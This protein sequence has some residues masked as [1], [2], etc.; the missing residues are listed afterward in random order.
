MNILQSISQ[1][2]IP[3]DVDRGQELV[4]VW[5]ATGRLADLLRGVGGCSPF[6]LSVLTKEKEWISE[7]LQNETLVSTLIE[8]DLCVDDLRSAKRR[9]AGYLALAELSGAL[10]LNRCTEILSDFADRSIQVSLDDALAPFIKAGKIP[11]NPGLF[12]LAMG[13]LG[14]QELN[15]SSDIDLIV[16]FEDAHLDPEGI[17]NRRQILSK[18]VRKAMKTLSDMT[19]DGYVFRT[20]L[21][22]RPDPSVTPVCVGT[23]AAMNYYESLGRTW[24][25]AAFI[26]ARVCAGDIDAGNTFLTAL[27]PFVWRRHLDFAAIE[28]AHDLRLKIRTKKGLPAQITLPGHDMKLGRGGIRE[29]EFFTQTRQLISGGR[30]PSLR[31]AKTLEGLDQLAAAGWVEDETAQRLKRHYI[32]HRHTEH[33]LQMVRDAQTQSLPHS[34]EGL[35]RIAAMQGM[36]VETF[37]EKTLSA[38]E[39]VHEETERFFTSP[40]QVSQDEGEAP[41][42]WGAGADELIA[43]WPHYPALR[44][45]RATGL[46]EKLRPRILNGLSLSADPDAALKDFDAF[47]RGLPSGVQLFSLFAANEKLVDLITSVSARSPALARYLGRNS[48]I[49]DAVLS[50]DF[51][52]SGIL[53]QNL[54]TD[55]SEQL[56]DAA[57]FETGLDRAR[58][59]QKEK[60]FQIGVLLLEGAI[61]PQEART[62]YS[63]LAKSSVAGLTPFALRFFE[64]KHGRIPD[65]DFTVVAMGSLGA[66]RLTSNSDLDLMVI[67]SADPSEQSDG[68]RSLFARQYFARLTQ[69]I[70]TSLSAPTAKGTMY[71]VDMRL[72]PSG[73]SGPVATRLAAFEDYQ[74]NEAW[75]WEHLALTQANPVFSTSIFDQQFNAIRDGILTSKM[76]WSA[77][78]QGLVEMR[79]RLFE[80]KT[81]AGIWDLKNGPGGLQDIELFAQACNLNIGRHLGDM[82]VAF[83]GTRLGET[84]SRDLSD[85]HKTL[86]DIKTCHVLLCTDGGQ[87]WPVGKGGWQVVEKHCNLSNEVQ[88]EDETSNLRNR[89]AAIIQKS[90]S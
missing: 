41:F 61:T 11:Q 3:I 8:S 35:A 54:K 24:E 58:V 43:N 10:P 37:C 77:I 50:G 87:N 47:L 23:S 89:A 19:D 86:S 60:H 81:Q 74:M 7:A 69:T 6:L 32:A 67:F 36:D 80:N 18:V 9:V 25:R 73:K 40:S 1:F 64:E 56:A 63:E 14:A 49:L 48:G 57:D 78:C 83:A 53:S 75:V 33:C 20:D 76:D 62:H 88:L 38:L 55:L 2:P 46:F 17:G 28:E 44:S 4:D 31:S 39:E 82:E 70:I 85:I 29:I 68:K 26:K 13:K 72:R 71:E 59:W 16:M 52:D 79:E 66:G 84:E 30:D 45:E 5:N 15:Y 22:L 12:V 65:M 51:F 42:T 34:Q 27:Q 90:L 21:R